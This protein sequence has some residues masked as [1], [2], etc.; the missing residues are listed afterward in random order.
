M[1]M[2][3]VGSTDTLPSEYMSMT[4]VGSTDTLPSEGSDRFPILNGGKCS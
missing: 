3:Y 1:S 2:T 4:Y